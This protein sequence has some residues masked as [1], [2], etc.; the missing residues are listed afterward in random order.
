MSVTTL[1]STHTPKIHI[2]KRG[3]ERGVVWFPLEEVEK[4][5]GYR[6]QRRGCSIGEKSSLRTGCAI[7]PTGNHARAKG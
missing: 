2:T 4:R 7:D 1:S 6:E 5:G 3:K